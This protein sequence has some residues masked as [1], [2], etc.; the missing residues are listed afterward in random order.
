MNKVRFSSVWMFVLYSNLWPIRSPLPPSLS[1]SSIYTACRKGNPPSIIATICSQ[2]VGGKHS[3]ATVYTSTVCSQPVQWCKSFLTNN[4]SMFRACR[5]GKW[6][7][8][9]PD[10]DCIHRKCI[11]KSLISSRL[12]PSQKLQ[13]ISTSQAFHFQII[14]KSPESSIFDLLQSF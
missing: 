2:P 6:T 8:H 14:T 13:K 1:N 10:L 12:E 5:R 4:Y 9:T 7:S 11:D 3:Q